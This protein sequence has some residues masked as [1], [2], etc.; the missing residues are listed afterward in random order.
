MHQSLSPAVMAQYRGLLCTGEI[1]AHSAEQHEEKTMTTSRGMGGGGAM[2]CPVVS[3]WPGSLQQPVLFVGCDMSGLYRSIDGGAHWTMLDYRDVQCSAPYLNSTQRYTAFSVAVDPATP[4]RVAGWHPHHGF[5]ISTDAGD[6]WPIQLPHLN[7]YAANPPNPLP[8][9][10]AFTGDGRVLLIGTG[11]N[12]QRIDPSSPS[13]AWVTVTTVAQDEVV[14]LACPA[15]QP[16][17]CLAATPAGVYWSTDAGQNFS[18]LPP[19]PG[20][21]DIACTSSPTGTVT[22]YAVVTTSSTSGAWMYDLPSSTVPSPA[23]AWTDI[24]VPQQA[25]APDPPAPAPPLPPQPPLKYRFV[26]VA[27]NDPNQPYI[28]AFNP[29]AE[30]SDPYWSVF[31]GTRSG[32]QVTWSGVYDGFQTH[33]KPNVEP[34][35]VEPP[36]PVGRDWGFGGTANGMS[37]DPNSP[38]RVLVT[39]MATVALTTDG[40]KPTNKVSWAQRYTQVRTDTTG[41]G[42]TTTG[43]D[44]TSVW[45][46]YQLPS[47]PQKKVHFIAATDVG[48]LRS[49]NG[50]QFFTLACFADVV[51]DPD[52]HKTTGALWGNCY[53]LAFK[54]STDPATA[55]V[56]A[57]VSNHHD[58]PLYKELNAVP[59]TQT[60]AGKPCLGAVVRS[61]DGG[62]NWR[63]IAGSKSEDWGE[64]FTSVGGAHPLPEGPV[65]SVLLHNTVLYAAVWE[66]GV[67]W[68]SDEGSTWYRLGSFSSSSPPSAQP[69]PRCH[70]LQFDRDG[71]L[72]C[73]TAAVKSAASCSPAFV[74][75]ALWQMPASRLTQAG[76][77]GTAEVTAEWVNKTATLPLGA[78]KHW[79]M[80]D[81]A[82]DPTNAQIIFVCSDRRGSQGPAGVFWTRDGGGT[83]QEKTLNNPDFLPTPA[84]VAT[85]YPWVTPF[86]VTILGDRLFLGTQT[87]GVFSS[88]YPTTPAGW[89]GWQPQW[90]EY[91]AIPFANVTRVE[92]T[93]DAEA[94]NSDLFLC[95]HGGSVWSVHRQWSWTLDHP[96]I[97]RTQVQTNP[98]VASAAT[99]V[100]EGFTGPEIGITTPGTRPTVTASLPGVTATVASLQPETPDLAR[101]QQLTMPCNLTFDPSILDSLFP[102]SSTDPPRS[103]DLSFS[104]GPFTCT[105]QLTLVFST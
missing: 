105:A 101:P 98:V 19:L 42:W 81:Y 45:H 16:T 41:T 60:C 96:A 6:T 85:H 18:P 20:V 102:T 47:D 27:E 73:V 22:V 79:S 83:W 70:R 49:T 26:S 64:T 12:L 39:N 8:T 30:D 3:S 88:P 104:S 14:A 57:A 40:G 100:L 56:F 54:P 63:T 24:S 36:R 11:Q 51:P 59:G 84:E 89:T 37:V 75:G 93:I 67:Y 1:P 46:Y 80:T 99:L 28:A 13:P 7:G 95:T 29:I 90:S 5:R 48:L 21:V 55:T 74:S 33:D 2:Y 58:L 17:W 77:P 44:V 87:S 50:G 38:Q 15:Q 23:P 32:S 62:Q 94:Q 9:C 10:G 43:L 92:G 52:P 4:N 34:G 103:L 66:K 76:A 65:V 97:S 82:I 72:Y 68:S 78:G 35:W 86:G 69:S 53:E 91:K 25:Y 31:K 61:D 71:N